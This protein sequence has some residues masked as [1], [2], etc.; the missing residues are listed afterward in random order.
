MDFFMV[1][2]S[3]SHIP[4]VSLLKEKDERLSSGQRLTSLEIFAEW[5]TRSVESVTRLQK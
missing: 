5:R 2:P 4:V 3:A 1:L